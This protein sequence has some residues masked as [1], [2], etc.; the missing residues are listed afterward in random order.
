MPRAELS[1]FCQKGI[2]SAGH[3]P[4]FRI[5]ESVKK[6]RAAAIAAARLFFTETRPHPHGSAGTPRAAS[7]FSA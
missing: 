5:M 7:R 2:F 6:R 3:L 4:D 1:L